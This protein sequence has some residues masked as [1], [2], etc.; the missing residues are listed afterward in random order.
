MF[1][2]ERIVFSIDEIK[3]IKYLGAMMKNK[4]D[5]ERDSTKNTNKIYRT[6]YEIWF[7]KRKINTTTKMKIWN[8]IFVPIPINGCES[9][10]L[11]DRLGNK[12]Q[13]MG[14]GILK[15]RKGVAKIKRLETK[16]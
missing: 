15:K 14:M 3:Y 16:K 9:W 11:I 8:T 2:H 5:F 4:E 6:L 12:I 13:T 1:H 7:N 10:L